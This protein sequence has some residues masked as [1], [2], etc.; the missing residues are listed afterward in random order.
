MQPSIY[1]LF[2]IMIIN[3]GIRFRTGYEGEVTLDRCLVQVV[4]A[5]S[6]LITQAEDHLSWS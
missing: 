6:V 3:S 1:S 4:M 2:G 5:H